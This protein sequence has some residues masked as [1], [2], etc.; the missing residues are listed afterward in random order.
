LQQGD[1]PQVDAGDPGGDGIEPTLVLPGR[2]L[3]QGESDRRERLERRRDGEP[4]PKQVSGAEA[5][6]RGDGWLLG[7]FEDSFLAESVVRRLATFA[8]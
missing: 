5:Q 7:S 4:T 6:G 1:R 8:G 3:R 2:L